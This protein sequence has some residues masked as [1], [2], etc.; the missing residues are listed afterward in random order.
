MTSLKK[1]DRFSLDLEGFMGDSDLLAAVTSVV[2]LG[3]L[4]ALA[5]LARR[6]AV[7]S[8]IHSPRRVRPV[9]AAARARQRARP[10]HIETAKVRDVGVARAAFLERWCGS[11]SQ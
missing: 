4:G 8:A 7:S 10:P 9:I 5:L 6:E 1:R 11:N 3:A 2:A